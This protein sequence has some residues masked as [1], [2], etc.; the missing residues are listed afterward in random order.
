[1]NILVQGFG[2][3]GSHLV[4]C[5]KELGFTTID[6]HDP[7]KGLIVSPE[8]ETAERAD[9]LFYCVNELDGLIGDG[10]L[11]ECMEGGTVVIK[12]TIAVGETE[13][14]QSMYPRIHFVYMPEFLREA[15]AFD[16]MMHPDHL[17][18]GAVDPTYS[19]TVDRMFIGLKAPRHFVEPKAAELYKLLSNSYPLLKLI[20]FNQVFDLCQTRDIDYEEVIAPFK[21]NKFNS[22]KYMNVVDKGGRGGGG[23]CLPKDINILLNTKGIELELRTLLRYVESINAYLLKFCPKK[24]VSDVQN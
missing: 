20:F 1:M 4:A 13:Q 8:S 11:I 23:K 17:I 19:V 22:G 12:T 2:M 5:L 15:Y 7:Y 3:V 16:D 24:G 9:V 18:Y 10:S 21:N 6:I 14:L